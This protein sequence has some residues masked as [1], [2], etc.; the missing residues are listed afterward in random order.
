MMGSAL[1]DAHVHVWRLGE[2]GC[3]WPTAADGPIHRDFALDDW[4]AASG[5]KARAI[6]VQSQES[7]AD[8]D[9]LIGIA[10]GDERVA[11]IVGWADLEAQDAS[12]R[13]RALAA[14][15]KLVGLR[16]MVQHREADWYD[17]P[18]LA[19]G[20]STMVDT[21]LRL[22]ALVRVQHLPSLARLADAYPLQIVIDHGA[23]PAIAAPDGYPLWYDAIAPLAD[24]E[25]VVVKLSGLLTECAGAPADRIA[26][27]A[28]ALIRLFG[29]DRV[30]W[31]SDWPVLNGVS[32]YGRWFEQARAL[33]PESLHPSV[34]GNA[35]R[36]FYGL[37]V[38]ARP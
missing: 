14:M 2:N 29:A 24:R 21:G 38:E 37:P 33:V 18:D 10:A 8:T 11:G 17:R 23:K 27:F 31:G 15:P 25:K 5:D 1:I 35:A 9:W 20:L 13:V 6:L 26:P 32:D 4:S 12:R 22:D 28:D 7:D 3:V 36:A 19:R 16:P 30:L 34:F